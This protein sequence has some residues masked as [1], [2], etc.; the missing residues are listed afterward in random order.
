MDLARL[1]LGEM[2]A[3]DP[4]FSEERARIRL[5]RLVRRISYNQ[6]ER[7]DN[8]E[9]AARANDKVGF[10]INYDCSFIINFDPSGIDLRLCEVRHHLLE[11]HHHL[12][13]GRLHREASPGQPAEVRGGSVTRKVQ[14][15]GREGPEGGGS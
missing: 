7:K 8:A 14:P 9:G 13:E 12:L 3:R 2:K 5:R 6:D 11:V 4:T 15:G 1:L 10:K